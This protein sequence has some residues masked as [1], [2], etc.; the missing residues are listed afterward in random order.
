[1]DLDLALEY[2]VAQVDLEGGAGRG[3]VGG[4][5]GGGETGRRRWIGKGGEGKR[6]KG[7]GRQGVGRGPWSRVTTGALRDRVITGPA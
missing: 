6:I 7:P 5:I 2:T 3:G 4:R 1:M